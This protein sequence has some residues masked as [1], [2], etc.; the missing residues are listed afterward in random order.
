MDDKQIQAQIDFIVRRFQE[1]V[2]KMELLSKE[3]KEAA[4][5]FSAMSSKFDSLLSTD[6]DLQNQIIELSKKSASGFSLSNK[7]NE[8][9][10]LTIIAVASDY[11]SLKKD[12][13]NFNNQ[14]PDMNGKIVGIVNRLNSFSTNEDL[15][16]LSSKIQ[17]HKDIMD[18]GLKDIKQAHSS[19]FA[20]YDKLKIVVDILSSEITTVKENSRT[21]N[22][23]ISSLKNELSIQ[24]QTMTTNIQNLKDELMKILDEKLSSIPEPII[25]SFDEDKKYI[26]DHIQNIQTEVRSANYKALSNETKIIMLEKKIAQLQT[27]GNS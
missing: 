8:N 21:F 15:G 27:Q 7:Q 26:H 5:L 4:I 10:T 18:N 9:L 16:I 14:L 20:S 19:I 17:V 3:V 22:A 6:S 2:P 11:S 1:A 23:L 12:V 13:N 24:K 25:Q